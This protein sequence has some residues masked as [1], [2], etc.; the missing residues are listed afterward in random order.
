MVRVFS[1]FPDYLRDPWG[2]GGT[3]G[4]S[5]SF[6]LLFQIV[7]V[8]SLDRAFGEFRTPFTGPFVPPVLGF[9]GREVSSLSFWAPDPL[10]EGGRTLS[11]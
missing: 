1:S 9:G 6:K 5:S 3:R 4:S 7:P 10:G 2:R 11:F 8:S